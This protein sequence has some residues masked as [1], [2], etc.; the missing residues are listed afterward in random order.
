VA[1]KV[2]NKKVQSCPKYFTETPQMIITDYLMTNQTTKQQSNEATEKGKN[3][4]VIP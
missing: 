4:H 3:E 1:W 2:D